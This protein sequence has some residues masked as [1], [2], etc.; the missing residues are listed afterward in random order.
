VATRQIADKI[1]AERKTKV[2]VI[3]KGFGR[4]IYFVV[5]ALKEKGIR[6]LELVNA[7]SFPHNGC[8]PPKKARR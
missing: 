7:T 5:S 2:K 8:R 4:G 1:L 3:F 6:I